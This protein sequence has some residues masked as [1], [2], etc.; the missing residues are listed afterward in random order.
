MV[1][2][3]EFEV[4]GRRDRG[5]PGTRWLDGF[6]KV[7][8]AESLELRGEKVMAGIESNGVTL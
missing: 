2:T 5:R 6:K 8:S 7:W 4:E 1:R 3:Y